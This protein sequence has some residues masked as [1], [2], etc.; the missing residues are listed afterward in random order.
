ML[1]TAFAAWLG[2][3]APPIIGGTATIGD[4]AVVALVD[5][6]GAPYCS[7]VLI[8][9]TVV[10]TAAHCVR[11]GGAELLPAGVFFGP[12]TD[13]PGVTIASDAVWVSPSYSSGTLEADVGLVRLVSAATVAPV[14]WRDAGE[15][16]LLGLDIRLVGFGIDADGLSGIKREVGAIV[17]SDDGAALRYLDGSCYGDSGGPVFL[18]APPRVVA[19]ISSGHADCSGGRAVRI[20]PLRGDLEEGV[21][22]LL[23]RNH[24]GCATTR[25]SPEVGLLAAAVLM[26]LRRR[27]RRQTST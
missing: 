26:V 5:A 22:S 16:A 11:R 21:A 4:P 3:A 17:T 8:E 13:E 27:A 18:V 6:T 10:L 23:R 12:R 20:P 7:G 1:S 2:V 9:P 24:D 15:G 25:P 14:P 19:V